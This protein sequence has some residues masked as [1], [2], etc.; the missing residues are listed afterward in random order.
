MGGVLREGMW[1]PCT[2][3]PSLSS[4][5]ADSS[6]VGLLFFSSSWGLGTRHWFLSVTD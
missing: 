2:Q 4:F 5:G 3:L 1:L 6:W